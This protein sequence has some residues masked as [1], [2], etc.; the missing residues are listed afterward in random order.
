MKKTAKKATPSI[1]KK[2][3]ASKEDKARDK[4]MG[5]REGSPMDMKA[6][7]AQAKKMMKKGKK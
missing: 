5:Y 4:K 1:M 3:E 6:D 2:V 7:M